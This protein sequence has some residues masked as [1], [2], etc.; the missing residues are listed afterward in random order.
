[1]GECDW[2]SASSSVS[3]LCVCNSRLRVSYHDMIMVITMMMLMICPHWQT[4]GYLNLAVTAFMETWN[5]GSS[6]PSKH[7]RSR[8]L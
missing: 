7:G 6:Y 8:S 2:I 1:M 4:I 3:H 5:L